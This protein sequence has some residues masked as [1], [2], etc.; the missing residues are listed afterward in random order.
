MQA[1]ATSKTTIKLQSIAPTESATKYHSM[2]VHLQVIKWKT[3]MSVELNPLDWGWKLSNGHYCPIMTDLNAAPGNIL[4][5]IQCN[6][7]I[8]KKR[9]CS[10]NTCSCKKH[11]LVCV[12]AC[13]NY[14]GI[15]SENCENEVN[16]DDFSDEE[17]DRNIFDVFD[18]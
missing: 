10:T 11:S 14:N 1:A 13:G 3:L 12:S 17:E 6:C 16:M 8:S 5:F 9:P 18:D 15:D 7:N 4:R 2:R